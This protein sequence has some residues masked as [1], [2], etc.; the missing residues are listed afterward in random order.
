[1]GFIYRHYKL[2]LDVLK[3]K[4][5]VDHY[6]TLFSSGLYRKMTVELLLCSAHSPPKL[7]YVFESE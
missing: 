3:T 7:N 5:Q 2:S 6:E 1:M 4:E